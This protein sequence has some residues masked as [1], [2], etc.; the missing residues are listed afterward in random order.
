VLINFFRDLDVGQQKT[1][2]LLRVVIQVV[3]NIEV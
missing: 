1:D 3:G 2:G